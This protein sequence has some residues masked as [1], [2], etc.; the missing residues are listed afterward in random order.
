MNESTSPSS[1]PGCLGALLRLL[2]GGGA[3]S[4]GPSRDNARPVEEATHAREP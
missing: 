3:A 1:N 2:F 4:D